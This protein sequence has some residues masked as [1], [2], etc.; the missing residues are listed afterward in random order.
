MQSPWLVLDPNVHGGVYLSGD[1]NDVMSAILSSHLGS[2]HPSYV[3][4]GMIYARALSPTSIDLCYY[5]GSTSVVLGNV[6]KTEHSFTPEGIGAGVPTGTVLPFAG[7]AAPS[8]WLLCYGQ[9]VSR[10]TYADL[11]SLIGTQYGAGN[12]STTFEVPDLRG[13]TVAGCDNMGGTAAG[14]LTGTSMSPNG[15][16]R[17]AVGGAQTHTLTVAQ[18]PLHGH[19]WQHDH[20]VQSSYTNA[21]TGG[22]PTGTDSSTGTHSA[23]TGAPSETEGRQIGGTGGSDPHNNV[24]PTMTLNYIIKT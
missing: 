20:G 13:R 8:G 10:T 21:L 5:D 15:N 11:F 17:G 14:R 2:D 23:W 6:D 18:M 9:A 16:A 12:G 22:I 4:E 3:V 19:A 1:L 7:S 24:Q